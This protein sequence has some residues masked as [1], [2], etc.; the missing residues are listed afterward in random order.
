MAITGNAYVVN[1]D[2]TNYLSAELREALTENNDGFEQLHMDNAEGMVNSYLARRFLLPII[3][4]ASTPAIRDCAL[5]LFHEKVELVTRALHDDTGV[6]ADKCRTWL[7][8]VADGELALE[9]EDEQVHQDAGAVG[10]SNMEFKDRVFTDNREEEGNDTTRDRIGINPSF[11][12]IG[13]TRV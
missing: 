6:A 5:A 9:N 3:N 10:D 13:T 12:G 1:A 11:T 2:I 4:P 7:Q 8:A